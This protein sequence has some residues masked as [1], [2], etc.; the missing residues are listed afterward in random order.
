MQRLRRIVWHGLAAISALLCVATCVLCGLSYWYSQAIVRLI[1]IPSHDQVDQEINAYY[2]DRGKFIAVFEHDI[3]SMKTLRMRGISNV[4]CRDDLYP[5]AMPAAGD[6]P[7][8]PTL[9][10]SQ[11]KI[12]FLGVAV[13][14]ENVA[15]EAPYLQQARGVSLPFWSVFFATALVPCLWI[16]RRRKWMREHR[17]A[18][19]Q[20]PSCGYDLRAT[21]G[22][23]PECGTHAKPKGAE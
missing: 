23:C 18:A 5:N 8:S 16:Y 10:G 2:V 22:R 12:S 1:T 4:G 3:T 14:A 6:F 11:P 7:Y 15:L 13:L 20:C 17:L 9:Q 19:G 21:P